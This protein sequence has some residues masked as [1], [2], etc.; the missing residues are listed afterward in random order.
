VDIK[1]EPVIADAFKN[2]L[3]FISFNIHRHPLSWIPKRVIAFRQ[4]TNFKR[5]QQASKGIDYPFGG[6]I[7]AASEIPFS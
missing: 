7:S 5:Q 6:F 1:R 4:T 2:S 3:R